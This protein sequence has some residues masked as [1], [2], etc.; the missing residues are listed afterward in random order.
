M[1][2]A[3]TY[4]VNIA[5][6]KTMIQALNQSRHRLH[7]G[8]I[9]FNNAVKAMAE[10]WSGDD[11]VAAQQACQEQ[12]QIG[13]AEEKRANELALYLDNYIDELIARE[14]RTASQLR[15]N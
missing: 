2:G 11:L 6:T 14:K 12:I 9:N 5:K 7:N 3:T 10:N 15:E 4:A 1:N 13:Y 8:L